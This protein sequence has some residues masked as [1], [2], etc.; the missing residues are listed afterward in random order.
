MWAA[1][2]TV[3]NAAAGGDGPDVPNLTD[4][5]YVWNRKTKTRS[6]LGHGT[7][8]T[9]YEI[10]HKSTKCKYALK[11]I[12]IKISDEKSWQFE[13]CRQNLEILKKNQPEFRKFRE[14]IWKQV[15]HLEREH[16]KGWKL[17]L[18]NY[19]RYEKEKKDDFNKQKN[20]IKRKIIQYQKEI[21][22]H[23]SL[24]EADMNKTNVVSLIAN[25]S[26][27]DDKPLGD[28]T[29]S[30][31]SKGVYLYLVTEKM[32]GTLK[33]ILRQERKAVTKWKPL[34][35]LRYFKSLLEAVMFC[36]KN[37]VIHRDLKPDNVLHKAGVLK[38]CDFGGSTKKL[39]VE[40]SFGAG[41]ANYS[42][43]EMA[44]LY[45]NRISDKSCRMT[46]GLDK[47]SLATIFYQLMAST[48][49]PLFRR[50]DEE[51][52]GTRTMEDIRINVVNFN[53]PGGNP[54]MEKINKLDERSQEIIKGLM[55]QEPEDRT[56][57]EEVLAN[58]NQMITELAAPPVTTETFHEDKGMFGELPYQE[59]DLSDPK[60][61]GYGEGHS[62]IM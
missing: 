10:Q 39:D 8:S 45:S 52:A 27:N 42:A 49:V 38:L 25:S 18:S 3:C 21:D 16:G 50:L 22:I 20:R 55:R 4:Y 43:P 9:V 46:I 1:L 17:W 62:P 29:P 24:S 58:V 61:G 33:E 12:P 11:E 47:W 40:D 7:L 30:K 6:V 19:K 13:A 60:H 54:E 5:R 26:V 28:D 37:G 59:V 56:P 41:A 32:D 57:L 36:H 31:H 35:A 44:R 51:E 23:L 48:D 53:N 14:G 2:L 34:K 15:R